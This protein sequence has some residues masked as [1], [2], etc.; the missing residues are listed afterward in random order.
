MVRSLSPKRHAVL[1]VIGPSVGSDRHTVL[2]CN[3]T[4]QVPMKIWIHPA[5]RNTLD[6]RRTTKDFVVWGWRGCGLRQ[7]PN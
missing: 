4:Y 1:V 5:L 3:Q 7:P 2:H 6:F